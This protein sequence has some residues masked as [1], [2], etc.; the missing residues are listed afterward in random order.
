MSGIKRRK[1]KTQQE[2]VANLKRF[3]QMANKDKKIRDMIIEEEQRMLDETLKQKLGPG[4][5]KQNR[6]P[7]SIMKGK[8][9][10]KI[11][12]KVGM[13]GSGM[14]LLLNKYFEQKMKKQSQMIQEKHNRAMRRL[15]PKKGITHP[16]WGAYRKLTDENIWSKKKKSRAPDSEFYKQ[17]FKK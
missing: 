5:K 4:R 11:A 3:H 2:A 8:K 10:P 1:P 12:A 15:A 14:G 16:E 13:V 9:T 6:T 7:Q 17:R